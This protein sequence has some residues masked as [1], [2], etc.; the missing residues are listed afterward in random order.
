[1]EVKRCLARPPLPS[2]TALPSRVGLFHSSLGRRNFPIPLILGPGFNS[3]L[4]GVGSGCLE[5]NR[6]APLPATGRCSPEV[7]AV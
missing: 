7:E 5:P 6:K 2:Q 1:M 3:F 4:P